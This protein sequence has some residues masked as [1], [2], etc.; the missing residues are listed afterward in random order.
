[1]MYCAHLERS[2]T[3]MMQMVM[4]VCRCSCFPP[5][6]LTTITCYYHLFTESLSAA[7]WSNQQRAINTMHSD[8]CQ[9]CLTIDYCNV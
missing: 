7:M 4:D 3:Q 8:G 1:M 2:C 6:H 5:T 9:S